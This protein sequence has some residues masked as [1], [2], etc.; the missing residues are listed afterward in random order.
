MSLA[1]LG[2]VGRVYAPFLLAN[3]EAVASG[4]ERVDCEIDGRR[5]VQKPF[6]YQAKCLR[7]LRAERAALSSADGAA[8][9]ALLA[10]TGSEALFA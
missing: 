9:D 7:W 2:E 6:P 3:A 8:L 1:L 10:G 4:A 5:W